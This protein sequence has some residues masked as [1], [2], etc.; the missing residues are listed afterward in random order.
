[1]EAEDWLKRVE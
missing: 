1:M